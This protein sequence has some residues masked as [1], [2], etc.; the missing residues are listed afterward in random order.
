MRTSW[1][2]G[3][4]NPVWPK[5]AER[6]VGGPPNGCPR[7]W[8]I[9]AGWTGFDRACRDRMTARTR[10]AAGQ[11]HSLQVP[12]EPEAVKRPRGRPRKPNPKA[13]LAGLSKE[14][15][16]ARAAQLARDVP[17]SELSMIRLAREFDVVPGLIHYYLGSRDHL[18]SGVL[19][20]Y[21]FQRISQMPKPTGRW[22]LDVRTIARLSID[23]ML[24]FRGAAEYIAS[25]NRFRL[26]QMVE[27]GET[28]Y[29]LEFFNAMADVLRRGGLS[30]RAAA[31]G[32]HLLMQ[33]ILSSAVSEIGGMSPAAHEGFI[34][35]RLSGLDPV[36]YAGACYIADEFATLDLAKTFDAG[37]EMLLEGIGKLR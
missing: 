24:T 16:I 14:V 25:H 23:T 5:D 26:F 6:S 28:D 33:F 13:D 1:V 18:I 35:Q 7:L 20:L 22:K 36:R 19:N 29:G 34:R 15:I 9:Q 11:L 21:Y 27:P 4:T 32:Y 10:S 3:G 17:L 2:E 37:L 8:S 12:R 30:P 31:M